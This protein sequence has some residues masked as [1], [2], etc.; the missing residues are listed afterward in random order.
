MSNNMCEFTTYSTPGED[1]FTGKVDEATEYYR[2]VFYGDEHYYGPAIDATL[3]EAV[4]ECLAEDG[5]VSIEGLCKQLGGPHPSEFDTTV[6]KG[7]RDLIWEASPLSP[8][9]SEA[10]E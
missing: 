7:L 2:K 6:A 4:R 3:H 8:D 10:G 9:A 5:S 1:P